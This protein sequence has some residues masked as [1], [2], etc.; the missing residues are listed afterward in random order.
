MK[1]IKITAEE[2]LGAD[3]VSDAAVYYSEAFAE[4]A[5]VR[6]R[7]FVIRWGYDFDLLKSWFSSELAVFYPHLTFAEVEV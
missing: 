7:E 1:L 2:P 4:P 5:L 3:D 6:G